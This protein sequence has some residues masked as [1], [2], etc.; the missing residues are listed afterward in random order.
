MARRVGRGADHRTAV[1]DAKPSRSCRPISP[2]VTHPVSNLESFGFRIEA[3]K[4][5]RYGRKKDR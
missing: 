4:D 5:I 2:S 3:R 1:N